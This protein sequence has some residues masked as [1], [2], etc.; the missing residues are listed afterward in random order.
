MNQK[1]YFLNDTSSCHA[2]S[3]KVVENFRHFMKKQEII[4]SLDVSVNGRADKKLIEACDI[5]VINAEGS[6]HHNA[7]WGCA[8]L[9][10]MSFALGKFIATKFL[11]N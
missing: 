4:G 6:I 5:L 2:G 7:P 10:A 3:A 1:I 8:L 9:E 11:E